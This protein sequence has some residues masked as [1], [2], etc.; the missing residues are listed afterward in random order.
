MAIL[1]VGP[2]TVLS[3]MAAIDDHALPR[4]RDVAANFGLTSRRW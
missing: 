2:V 3:F 4:S 1:G